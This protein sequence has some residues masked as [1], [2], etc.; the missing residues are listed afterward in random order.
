M[1][2]VSS[3]GP[4]QRGHAFSMTDQSSSGMNVSIGKEMA[5]DLMMM[6]ALMRGANSLLYFTMSVW[7]GRSPR[8]ALAAMWGSC[9]GLILIEV[10]GQR[11]GVCLAIEP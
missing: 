5:F 11:R 3:V 1:Q 2:S 4:E 8:V 9:W 6:S 7:D 10:V